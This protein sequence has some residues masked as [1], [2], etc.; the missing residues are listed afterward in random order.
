MKYETG[1]IVRFAKCLIRNGLYEVVEHDS[2]VTV[3]NDSCTSE[4]KVNAGE[5]ILVCKMCDRKDL[6]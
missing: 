3:T 5:L 4:F 2:N 1:D 6:D